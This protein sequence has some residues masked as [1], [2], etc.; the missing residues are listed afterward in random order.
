MSMSGWPGAACI[1]S[2]IRRF[3]T[4]PEAG[5]K[6]VIRSRIIPLRSTTLICPAPSPKSRSRVRAASTSRSAPSPP[7]K[8]SRLRTAKSSSCCVDTSSGL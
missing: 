4:V 8:S 3:W 2:T 1:P 5:A 6:S 7:P